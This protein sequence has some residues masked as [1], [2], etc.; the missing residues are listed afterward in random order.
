MRSCAYR[1]AVCDPAGA[2]YALKR[3][4]YASALGVALT[5]RTFEYVPFDTNGSPWNSRVRFGV[6]VKL[7][8]VLMSTVVWSR[9]A[10][11]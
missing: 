9:C 2:V 7:M 10:N 5:S 6:A 3:P 8:R 1:K 4:S 11:E